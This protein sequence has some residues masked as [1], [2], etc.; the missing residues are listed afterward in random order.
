MEELIE[1]ENFK[2][3]TKI[4]EALFDAFNLEIKG[5]FTEKEIDNFK[6]KLKKLES[7]NI[8]L[9]NVT[10]ILSTFE[11]ADDISSIFLKNKSLQEEKIYKKIF[12]AVCKFKTFPE[13][14]KI[15]IIKNL[16][17][18]SLVFLPPEESFKLEYENSE[19]RFSYIRGK[20]SIKISNEEL[21]ILEKEIKE[22]KNVKK[23]FD[24]FSKEINEAV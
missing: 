16:N 24:D 2:F 22:Y 9:K 17:D 21:E 4:I 18:D 12:D 13:I 11:E 7:G 19:N 20:E 3:E 14:H 6:L 10:L 1:L 5:N 23:I 15:E 8:N